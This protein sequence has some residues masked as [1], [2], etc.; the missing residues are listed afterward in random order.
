MQT[1]LLPTHLAGFVDRFILPA[2]QARWRAG[3]AA[4]HRAG[5]LLRCLPRHLD[6]HRVRQLSGDEALPSVLV[7]QYGAHTGI[8]FDADGPRAGRL[9]EAVDLEHDAVFS[10]LPGQLALCFFHEGWVWRCQHPAPW[11]R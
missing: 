1:V 3:L 6:P 11:P 2:R 8:W 9:G 4:P 5:K 10:L 7:W